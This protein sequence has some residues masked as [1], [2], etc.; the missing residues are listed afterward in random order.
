MILDFSEDTLHQAS[1][2]IFA[3]TTRGN[4]KIRK[5]TFQTFSYIVEQN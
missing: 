4:K 2:K 1:K 5:N 3:K